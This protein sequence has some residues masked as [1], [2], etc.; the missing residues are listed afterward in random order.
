M[1]H[2]CHVYLSYFL[3]MLLARLM[4]YLMF[5]QLINRMINVYWMLSMCPLVLCPMNILL[6][7]R[8]LMVVLLFINLYFM[9][10]FTAIIYTFNLPPT[11]TLSA[12]CAASNVQIRSFN[13]IYHLI[14]DIQ[15]EIGKK[16]PL[17]STEIVSGLYNSYS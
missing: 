10:R 6:L 5:Y 2:L 8:N 17:L 9:S 16:L 12:K 1:I 3:V 7:R 4:H 13:V 14:N 15:R 11:P